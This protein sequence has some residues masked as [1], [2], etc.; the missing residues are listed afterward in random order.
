MLAAD[1]LQLQSA[2]K[3]QATALKE[4][5]F[6]LHHS[7]LSAFHMLAG[8]MYTLL[9]VVTVVAHELLIPSLSLCFG[10]RTNS[11]R[12]YTS[13]RLSWIRYHNVH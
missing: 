10:S 2:L 13:C 9:L 5:E 12:W 7:N 11:D 6:N 3:Q 8:Y 4:K 1:K